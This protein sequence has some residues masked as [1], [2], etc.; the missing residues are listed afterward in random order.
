[1]ACCCSLW[2]WKI[3]ASSCCSLCI[4]GAAFVLQKWHPILCLIAM[5]VFAGYLYILRRNKK[6]IV[7][8]GGLCQ[9]NNKHVQDGEMRRKLGWGIWL[10]FIKRS[11]VYF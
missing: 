3:S 10:W 8:R 1:V 11:E 2:W 4:Q 5:C 6:K 9:T 7:I